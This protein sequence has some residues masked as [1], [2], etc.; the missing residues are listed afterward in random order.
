ML[1]VQSNGGIKFKERCETTTQC[2]VI[3][4]QDRQGEKGQV[5]CL[6]EANSRISSFRS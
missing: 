5:V 2:N 6:P 3:I 4:R 1:A